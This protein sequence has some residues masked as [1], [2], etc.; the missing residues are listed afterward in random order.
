MAGISSSSPQTVVPC[1][2]HTY[3]DLLVREGLGKNYHADEEDEQ[4]G[5]RALNESAGRKCAISTS[6]SW[7]RMRVIVRKPGGQ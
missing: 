3:A 2:E 1:L 4:W 5:K 7:G 6:L